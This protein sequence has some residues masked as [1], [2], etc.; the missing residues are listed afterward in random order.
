MALRVGG[1]SSKTR[2]DI[3]AD[4]TEPVVRT[5]EAVRDHK[6]DELALLWGWVDHQRGPAF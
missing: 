1:E 5:I 2:S 3:E 6:V 4:A